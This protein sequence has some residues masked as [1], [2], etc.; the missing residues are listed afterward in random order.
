MENMIQTEAAQAVSKTMK[1]KADD[2]TPKGT[3]FIHSS[4]RIPFLAF[5]F[6]DGFLVHTC[7]ADFDA[8]IT[9][10]PVK[11]KSSKGPANIVLL[12]DKR[13]QLQI[14]VNGMMCKEAQHR[15]SVFLK[16]YLKHGHAF[17]SKLNEQMK[18]IK[19]AA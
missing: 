9:N 12:H 13:E 10:R 4:M 16:M 3:E 5:L 19:K 2:L 17:I 15:Y 14:K 6:N 11:S 18:F 1:Y 8:F 7:R